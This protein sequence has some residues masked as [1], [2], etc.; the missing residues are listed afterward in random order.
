MKATLGQTLMAAL[1]QP[2]QEQ[3]EAEP[4]PLGSKE[5]CFVRPC[6][7]F[8]LEGQIFALTC[9]RHLFTFH[10][11]WSSDMTS[12]AEL[13]VCVCVTS[14]LIHWLKYEWQFRRSLRT[15]TKRSKCSPFS[16]PLLENILLPIAKASFLHTLLRSPMTCRSFK[17]CCVC[18]WSQQL[19]FFLRVFTQRK[20]NWSY[21]F[22]VSVSQL[23]VFIAPFVAVS[24]KKSFLCVHLTL[25][26]VQALTGNL[27]HTDKDLHGNCCWFF[28]LCSP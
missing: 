2:G 23:T 22:V 17:M 21:P 15:S 8:T 11:I 5:F 10:Y 26:L 4:W 19:F 25:T 24:A 28:S 27:H 16:S 3:E 6:D 13:C 9:L 12:L 18:F 14:F 1:I 7:S 20:G